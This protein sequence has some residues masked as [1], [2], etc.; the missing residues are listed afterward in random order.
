VEVRDPGNLDGLG[1]DLN[2]TLGARADGL[3]NN[4]SSSRATDSI[5][6]EGNPPSASPVVDAQKLRANGL[7][8]E[9]SEQ[10]AIAGGAWGAVSTRSDLYACW[11]VVNGYQK[12]DTEGLAQTSKPLVPTVSRRFFMVLDRSNVVRA[13]DK[14]RIVVFRELPID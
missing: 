3:W 7:A 6:H 1:F 8:N 13:S 9:W 14:A 12:S 5:L 2:E 11:F 4:N 10:L